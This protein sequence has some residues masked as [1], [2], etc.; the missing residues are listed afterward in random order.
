MIKQGS[1][2]IVA[3]ECS[4]R[5]WQ[6]T[7]PHRKQAC[8]VHGLTKNAALTVA[9]LGVQVNAV[10]PGMIHSAITDSL[11]PEMAA[12]GRQI[13]PSGRWG[14]PSELANC[15]LWLLSD[16]SRLLNG[17]MLMADEGWSIS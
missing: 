13:I 11:P 7:A 9:K 2:A 14:Q 16:A 1:G 15:V 17:D 4:S 3:S 5:V 6:P 12:L 8:G 10:A